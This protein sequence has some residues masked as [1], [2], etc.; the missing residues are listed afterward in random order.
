M[1]IVSGKSKQNKNHMLQIMWQPHI[2][3]H[4]YTRG[5][6]TDWSRLLASRMWRCIAW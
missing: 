6:I 1:R 4:S 5:N 3:L 2:A